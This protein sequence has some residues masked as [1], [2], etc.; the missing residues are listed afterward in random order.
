MTGTRNLLW[1]IPLSAILTAPFW[2]P[3]AASFLNPRGNF[4]SGAVNS[5]YIP[6]TFS[7]EG[8]TF[9]QTREGLDDFLLS[10]EL[11]STVGSET[12]LELRKVQATVY[13]NDRRPILISSGEALYD[14]SRNILTLL[15]NV[16]IVSEDGYRIRTEALRYLVKYKKIKTAAPV[17]LT[18]ENSRVTGTGLYCDLASGAFRVGGRVSFDIR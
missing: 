7:L 12:R 2:W 16:E 5:T 18:G 17:E 10:A 9:T 14:T 1:F 15:D 4:G 3:H 6:K 13:D 11:L 8:V